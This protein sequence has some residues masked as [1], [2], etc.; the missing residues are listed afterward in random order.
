MHSCILSTPV[1]LMHNCVLRTPVLLYSKNPCFIPI[2]FDVAQ[3]SN[4]SG[5]K[6][7][8]PKPHRLYHDEW[9]RLYPLIHFDRSLRVMYCISCREANVKNSLANGIPE[10]PE[11]MRLKSLQRHFDL[12]KAPKRGSERYSN[13]HAA[14]LQLLMMRPAIGPF[15][16]TGH[17]QQLHGI[18][19]LIITAYSLLGHQLSIPIA[20]YG[21]IMETQRTNH[22]PD[23]PIQHCNPHGA[24]EALECIEAESDDVVLLN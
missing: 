22:T 16:N 7:Q 10:G 17:D 21:P 13:S 5:S 8:K 3:G 2:H 23:V 6:K 19:C 12:D 11:A 15:V 20:A 24:K 1:P 4:G 9:K 18:C 14:A